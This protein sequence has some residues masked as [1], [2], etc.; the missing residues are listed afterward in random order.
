M[1]PIQKAA[2][3]FAAAL[4]ICSNSSQAQ[5]VQ[6][7]TAAI[8]AKKEID[9]C[10]RKFY[11]LLSYQNSKLDNVDS[12]PELFETDGTLT[13]TFGNQPLLWTAPQFVAFLK[14]GAAQGARDRTETELY[15]HTDIFGN[16]AHRF[17]TYSLKMT[18]GVKPEERRGI[19]SIQLVKQ[20]GKWL[21]H[22][23]VWDRES[24]VI[25][26]PKA[27]GGK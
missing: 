20:N 8:Q 18:V 13:A 14:N 10:I 4:I 7:D 23:L 24:D 22:S 26:I 21:I 1:K 25:K 5:A 19:N 27:Y 3:F 9:A 2:F 17:S 16:I 12:L 6:T 11:N 15:E